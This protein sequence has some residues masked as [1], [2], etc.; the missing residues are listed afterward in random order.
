[1][2]DWGSSCRAALEWIRGWLSDAARRTA[3]NRGRPSVLT[4]RAGR[5]RAGTWMRPDQRRG[6]ARPRDASRDVLERRS[7]DDPC[8]AD[9]LGRNQR[10]GG[11]DQGQVEPIAAHASECAMLVRRLALV[12]GPDPRRS[13]P[14]R[15]AARRRRLRDVP[16]LTMLGANDMADRSTM[17][18]LGDERDREQERERRADPPGPVR[19]SALT[20]ARRFARG[21]QHPRSMGDR[22]GP[23]IAPAGARSSWTLRH[24]HDRP[25]MT[26]GRATEPAPCVLDRVDP[27]FDRT[28]S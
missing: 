14:S 28:I 7:R 22:L 24:E 12:R 27:R 3:R 17:H 13:T 5:G 6:S 9:R 1:M 4:F 23:S 11:L 10:K 26:T 15:G 25:P 21:L 18:N 2:G 20:I 8:C 16:Q 19:G